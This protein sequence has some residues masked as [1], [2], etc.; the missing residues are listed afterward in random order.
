MGK[1]K[2]LFITLLIMALVMMAAA[3]QKDALASD[4]ESFELSKTE[5]TIDVV[6][7]SEYNTQYRIANGDY[8]NSVYSLGNSIVEAVSNNTKVLKLEKV[9]GPSGSGV[10]Y[11]YWVIIPINSGTTTIDCFDGYGRKKSVTVTVNNTIRTM[12]LNQNDLRFN[13]TDD[14]AKPK[15]IGNDGN[16][17]I[18]PKSSPHIMEVTSQNQAVVSVERCEGRSVNGKMFYSWNVIPGVSGTTTL[19]CE[20]DFGQSVLVN[21]IVNRTL[22]PFKLNTNTLTIDNYE[23]E[24]NTATVGWGSKSIHRTSGPSIKNVTSQNEKI[25]RVEIVKEKYMDP[26]WVLH[27]G[28][29]GTTTIKCED[30]FGRYAYVKVT[31]DNHPLKLNVKN[32]V[33]D[34]YYPGDEWDTVGNDINNKIYPLDSSIVKV[35]VKN[36]EIVSI[37]KDTVIDGDSTTWQIKPV[38]PGKTKI[39]CSDKKGNVVPVNVTVTQNCISE[40]I[41]RKTSLNKVLYGTNKIYGQTTPNS[42]IVVKTIG[43]KYKTKSNSKGRFNSYIP[44]SKIGTKVACTIKYKGATY[45]ASTKIAKSKP[46]IRLSTVYRHSKNI[47]VKLSKVNIGDA[48]KIKVGRKTYKKKLKAGKKNYTIKLKGKKKAGSKV[49]VILKNKFKQTLN[50]KKGK[51]YYASKIKKGM[52]KKQ[53]KLIPGWGSP[54]SVSVQGSVTIWWY[55]DSYLTF[56]KGKLDGWH[57]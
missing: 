40:F 8:V 26:Y 2:C 1:R 14:E 11:P 51:V 21:V 23:D 32:Y 25:V 52:T 31:V 4:Q 18:Y 34:S 10:Q 38:S 41:R 20:D 5:L 13:C 28:E 29:A 6:D 43:K 49:E 15:T 27:S 36:K 53:C 24:G 44:L 7:D 17:D 47:K 50:T 39:E 56:Y 37:T 12:V 3:V 48:I 30:G 46:S 57:Y 22:N 55:H 16:C 42:I 45:T 9:D 54:D 33:I 35:T 19:T